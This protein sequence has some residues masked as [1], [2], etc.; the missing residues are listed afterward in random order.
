MNRSG[1]L[2]V[3]CLVTLLGHASGQEKKIE[4]TPVKY[5]GLK[6]EVLKHRGKVVVVDF[7]GGF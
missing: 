7:W 2:A 1:V 5:D 3:A 6:Q 4:M